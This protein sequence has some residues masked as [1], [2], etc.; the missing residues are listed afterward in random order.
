LNYPK[1]NLLFYPLIGEL[2]DLILEVGRAKTSLIFR[3][4]LEISN[5]EEMTSEVTTKKNELADLSE[6]K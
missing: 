6:L 3:Y 4:I 5:R 2:R 1:I